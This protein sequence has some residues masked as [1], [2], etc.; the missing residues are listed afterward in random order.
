MKK[1]F[2][3]IFSVMLMISL[4]ACQSTA[5]PENTV[6]GYFEAAKLSDAAKANTFINPKNVSSE[7][8]SSGTSSGNKE[9]TDILNSVTDY[10]NSN[11]K[12]VTYSIKNEDDKEN[13]AIVTVDCKF[14]DASAILK[15][16]MADYVAQA[17]AK[18]FTSSQNPDDSAKEIT[19]LVIDKTKTAKETFIEKTIKVNCVKINGK[20]YIDKEDD[21][22]RNVFDSNLVSAGKDISSAFGESGSSSSS[23]NSQAS[24]SE[25]VSK[26][27]NNVL[28][29]DDFKL[30][31]T[32]Y[33]VIA[34]G[35]TGNDYGKKPVIAFWYKVTNISGK[36]L[37]PDDAWIS[38]FK[39]IQDNDP[40][41]VNELN[42]GT[43]PDDKFLD[44]QSHKIKKGGTVENA[45]AYELSDTKTPVS[46]KATDG[47][48]DIGEQSFK[49]N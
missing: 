16:A 36:E 48:K 33:K 31:I 14:V 4:T 15:D 35:E 6:N 26:F 23:E 1:S 37:E 8:T 46:L 40:N 19:K 24:S 49:L 3:Y 21:D 38:M 9:E 28:T 11:N 20:W 29:T 32:K 10:I 18:A 42:I 34:P 7:G 22:L 5:N 45:I 12:K 43:L 2:C 44:T 13:S 30:E 17:F 41:S 39:A 27:Q 25:S 47:D